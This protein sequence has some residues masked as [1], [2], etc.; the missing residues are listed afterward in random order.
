MARK[1]TEKLELRVTE[2]LD[3][4]VSKEQERLEDEMESHVSKAETVRR[5]LNMLMMVRSTPGTSL[6]VPL[7]KGLM[8]REFLEQNDVDVPSELNNMEDTT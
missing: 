2:T 5:M 1:K 3:Q 6:G 8:F 7:E 4:W